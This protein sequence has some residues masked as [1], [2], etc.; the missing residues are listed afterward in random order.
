MTFPGPPKEN[1]PSESVLTLT[2]HSYPLVCTFD[3]FLQLLENTAI[4]LDRQNF[5]DVQRTTYPLSHEILGARQSH[6][7]QLVDFYSFKLDYWPRFSQALIKGFSAHLVFSE[8]MGVIKGSESSRQ[9]L[10]PLSREQ[11][12]KRSSR[13]APS[14]ASESD[15]SRVYDLFEVYESTKRQSGHFDYVDRVVKLLRALHR[16]PKLRQI[17]CKSFDEVYVDEIQDHRCLDLELLFSI[18]RNGRGFHFAGDTAQAISQ[19]STFRFADVKRMI[20]DHFSAARRATNQ[21]QLA[22]AEMFLLSKNYRSHQGI[23]AVASMI[24]EMIWTGFPETVDKLEPEVGNLSGPKPV[25]FVGC[26]AK[27]IFTNIGDSDQLCELTHDF[28]AE[29]VILV[30]DAGGKAALRKQIKNA[31]LILTVLESKGME[32]DDVTLWNFFSDC[33]D[34][35][36]VRSLVSLKSKLATFDRERHSAMCSELKTLYVAITRARIQLFIVE[37]S[38]DTAATVQKILS[39]D[40]SEKLIESTAPHHADFAVRVEMMQPRASVDPLAWARKA[41][42]FMQ[43]RMLEESVMAF[44]KAGDHRGETTAKA[45]LREEKARECRT[46]KDI[47]GFELNLEAAYS[48]YIEIELTEDA[49]R[50]LESLGQF[51]RAARLWLVNDQPSRAARLFLKAGRPQDAISSHHNAHEHAEAAMILR[52]EKQWDNLV[53]CIVQYRDQ[54]PAAVLRSYGLLCKLLLKQRKLTGASR[55]HAIALLGSPT[56]QEECFLEYGMNENLVTLYRDQRRY[57]DL[58]H[59]YSKIGQLENALGLALTKNLVQPGGSLKEPEVLRMLDLTWA[60]RLIAGTHQA[61]EAKFQSSSITLSPKMAISIQ[62]WRAIQALW[63]SN[64]AEFRQHADTI[65][66]TAAGRFLCLHKTLYHGSWA[67]VNHFDTIPFETVQKAIECVKDFTLKT[68]PDAV[69]AMSLVSGLW[70]PLDVQSRPFLLPWSPL[71]KNRVQDG[72]LDLQQVVKSWILDGI[73]SSVLALDSRVRKL[74]NLKW[75]ERCVFFL[76]RSTILLLLIPKL[77]GLI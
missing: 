47:E 1:L 16:E 10:T 24:M 13:L 28:G 69:M 59:L 70:T 7:P 46:K 54:F 56:A 53:D 41:E 66:D 43:R 35:A 26:D 42:E 55:E 72:D 64:I 29:Q 49:V 68:E 40:D 33:P 50:M 8:I 17:L 37:D 5:E 77:L 38:S 73:A 71:V 20:F 3:H 75:P 18:A 65:G 45:L 57:E 25:L 36:G 39:R 2:D 32:F 34:Q 63:T 44:R 23:L 58:Y 61:L 67:Q 76:T 6:Q 19:D 31:P 52:T 51:E 27:S 9:T 74:W 14:F 48:L 4:S 11:Y 15:R 62:Q 12:L 60:Q 21:D 30:R 22:H